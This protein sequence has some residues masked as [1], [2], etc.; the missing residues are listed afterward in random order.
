[1]PAESR[2][3]KGGAAAMDFAWFVVRMMQHPA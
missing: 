1:M 3:Q 2:F